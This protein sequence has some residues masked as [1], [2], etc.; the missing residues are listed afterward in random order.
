[1]L[2]L[3]FWRPTTGPSLGPARLVTSPSSSSN[4]TS[5]SSGLLVTAPSSSS[6]VTQVVS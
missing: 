5:P 6:N 2:I 4:L 3:W 1:M